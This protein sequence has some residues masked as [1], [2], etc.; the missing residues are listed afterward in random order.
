MRGGPLFSRLLHLMIG[1][2]AA[3]ARWMVPKPKRFMFPDL[4]HQ[5]LVPADLQV[6]SSRLVITAPCTEGTCIA[7][8]YRL[9]PTFVVSFHET[10]LTMDVDESKKHGSAGPEALVRLLGVITSKNARHSRGRRV[11]PS[12]EFDS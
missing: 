2:W 7:S 11:K 6:V 5:R 12:L 1:G 3:G 9:N 4:V 10:R 8:F